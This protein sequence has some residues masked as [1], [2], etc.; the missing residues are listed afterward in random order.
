MPAAPRTDPG[1]RNY[2]TGLLPRIGR[3]AAGTPPRAWPGG[4]RCRSW[5]RAKPFLTRLWVRSTCFAVGRSLWPGPFPPPT[6]RADSRRPLFAGFAGTTGL[7]DF[8]PPCI[9]VV[10]LCGFTAR[11]C[12]GAQVG[13]GTSRLPREVRACVDGASDPAG[14]GSLWRNE[15]PGVA[16]GI[17]KEPRRPG[18]ATISGLD[19]Q[20]ARPPVNASPSP[21]RTPT[22]D[23]GPAW[24]AKPS[25]YGTLIHNTSPASAGALAK[26]LHFMS[27]A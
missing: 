25:P 20:P 5:G 8:P 16:F 14:P 13:C 21:L 27:P 19:T 1:G 18:G 7:S 3:P 23:S 4:S 26:P 11:A 24:L 10:S 17:C 15:R 6:P 12:A 9:A 2:R 22:H